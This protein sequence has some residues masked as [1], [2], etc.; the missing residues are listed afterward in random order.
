M[1]T[2]D[3]FLF[4]LL[5]LYYVVFLAS[6]TCSFVCSHSRK[7][8]Q[9]IKKQF[10]LFYSSLQQNNFYCSN[11]YQPKDNQIRRKVKTSYYMDTFLF[12]HHVSSLNVQF[13]SCIKRLYALKALFPVEYR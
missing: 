4:G 5:Q 2:S 8:L 12:L 1:I 11:N 13:L 9:Q 10:E 6:V 7:I 3:C